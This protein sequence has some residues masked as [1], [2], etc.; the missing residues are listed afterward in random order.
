MSASPGASD[1]SSTWASSSRR[2]A[3]QPISTSSTGDRMSPRPGSHGPA[4]CGFGR[5]ADIRRSN[6][7]LVTYLAKY[8]TKE[9]AAAA[10]DQTARRAGPPKY[11]RRVRWSR[12]WCTWSRREASRWE[13]WWFV[14]AV[15]SHSAIDVTAAVAGWFL[16]QSQ[17]AIVSMTST[18]PAD[19]AALTGVSLEGRPTQTYWVVRVISSLPAGTASSFLVFDDRTLNLV[20]VS[21][22]D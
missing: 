15:P 6:P 4:E 1:G 21:S 14:D 20:E 10:G 17:P 11:F 16:T 5:I 3:A 18:L 7:R 19:A 2:S 9:L 12:G 8:L 13:R 22:G